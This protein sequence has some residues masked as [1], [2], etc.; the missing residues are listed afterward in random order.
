MLTSQ[1]FKGYG[2]EDIDPNPARTSKST[3]T[4]HWQIVGQK[5]MQ[6][7]SNVIAKVKP[8]E[9][10]SNVFRLENHGDDPKNCA[11]TDKSKIELDML[12]QYKSKKHKICMPKSVRHKRKNANIQSR[13]D[14]DTIDTEKFHKMM[15]YHCVTI[16]GRFNVV[17]QK[18]VHAA[19]HWKDCPMEMLTLISC[20]VN[21]RRMENKSRYRN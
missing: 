11:P 16:V 13:C 7:G 15:A 12:I 5:P 14:G 6:L 19:N 10:N 4:Q 20:A 21:V 9:D 1:P 2:H 8:N 17:N 18:I 3:S